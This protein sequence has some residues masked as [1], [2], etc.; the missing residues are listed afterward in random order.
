[1]LFQATRGCR[2]RLPARMK[3]FLWL[4]L[5]LGGCISDLAPRECTHD[6]DCLEDSEVGK[7]LPGGAVSGKNWCAFPADPNACLSKEKWGVLSGDGLADTCVRQ[8]E[9]QD[10]P[11]DAPIAGN[12]D[13]PFMSDADTDVVHLRVV[14]DSTWCNG[15]VVTADRTINCG[16]TCEA[17]LTVPSVLLVAQPGTRQGR[18][19][20]V[21]AW[22]DPNCGGN[23]T[24]PVNLTSSRTQTVHISFS[25]RACVDPISGSDEA[26]GTCSSPLK[27]ITHA[28][29]SVPAGDLV[30]LK[31]GTYSSAA[32]GET[33]P[34]E[35]PDG[36]AVI[37]DEDNLG[38][39]ST[40][41]Y[42]SGS[43]KVTS[44]VVATL[45][46]GSNTT[47]AGL[48]IFAP[49]VPG[50]GEPVEIAVQG[51][52]NVVIRNN[53]FVGRSG[54]AVR[55][56]NSFGRT[57]SS[58]NMTNHAYGIYSISSGV[59][60]ERNTIR[61][62]A[63]GVYIVQTESDTVYADLGGGM[64]SSVGLNILSCNTTADVRNDTGITYALADFW[65][66]PTPTVGC[67]DVAGAD[68]CGPKSDNT[69]LRAQGAQQVPTGACP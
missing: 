44:S 16:P 52:Q 22:S 41:I 38:N 39:G 66:H 63:Y 48:G 2:I 42:I 55:V 46:P 36:V 57:I 69:G 3:P 17:D 62:N 13:S 29:S 14:V 35:I 19:C 67:R 1:M 15:S 24:C 9:Q 6:S 7:C 43:A 26:R 10:G 40:P 23:G 50:F 51:R 18:P 47:I 4:T 59:R 37:G 61:L 56:E 12:L 53:S 34:I 45:L 31:P 60:I 21:D 5:Y 49:E 64:S 28:F 68:F 33:F 54:A 58:N 8:A 20:Y 27:T 30:Q 32:N 25:P 65:D 11:A